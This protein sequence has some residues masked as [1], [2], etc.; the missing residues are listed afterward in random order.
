[1]DL[2][3]KDYRSV[4]DLVESVYS[5]P[6]KGDMFGAL[7][8]GIDRL[9]G[10][11]SGFIVTVDPDTTT[12]LS[13]PLAYNLGPG[14]VDAY[15]R[16]YKSLD[17][18]VVERVVPVNRMVQYADFMSPRKLS[19]SEYGCDFLLPSGSFHCTA[20]QLVSQGDQMCG[21]GFHRN[22]GDRAF[23][24]RERRI[25]DMVLPH[26]S[27]ALHNIDLMDTTAASIELGVII[28]GNDEKVLFM[29]ETARTILN[30]HRPSLV[31]EACSNTA[32][33]FFKG[34]AGTYRVLVRKGGRRGKT[35]LLEPVLS[36][37]SLG[38]RLAPFG[39]TPRQR[40]IVMLVLRGLSNREIAERL[41][42]AEQTVKDHL[43]DVFEK[44]NVHSRSEMA[45]RVLGLDGRIDN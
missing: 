10:I 13:A 1:M 24:D 26:V 20:S 36:A 4:L 29:N 14:V 8:E 28:I 32:P 7:F 6:E 41:F 17:P 11:A 37:R 40:E 21:L 2:T 42:I 5:F 16:R 35:I 18:F 12:V 39:L 27:R 44:T 33:T 30:G 34:A 43:R 22:K 3:L 25:V 15:L 19:D 9:V 31:V 38:P 45:A 23:T